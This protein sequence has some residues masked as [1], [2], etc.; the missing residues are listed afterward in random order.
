MKSF[1]INERERERKCD[2][3]RGSRI[4]SKEDEEIQ[5]K[6][7]GTKCAKWENANNVN[8]VQGVDKIL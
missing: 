7:F 8:C 6:V 3:L 5:R 1:E 4:T 2:A